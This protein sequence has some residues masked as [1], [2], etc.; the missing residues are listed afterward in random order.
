[1]VFRFRFDSVP[2]DL[3]PFVRLLTQSKLEREKNGYKNNFIYS[4]LLQKQCAF[5]IE[6][7][8]NNAD[9]AF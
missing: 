3:A 6:A 4:P 1:M 7:Y 5:T 2:F 8:A 9:G